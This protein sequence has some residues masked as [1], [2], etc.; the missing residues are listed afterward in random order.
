[1]EIAIFESVTTE[2]A[3]TELEAEGKKY[4]GLYV[5][6]EDAPQRKY[7][8]DKAS[9]IATLKKKVD[10]VRIDAAKTY[11][12][13]VEKQAAAIHERLDEANAPFQV[14]IDDYTLERKKIL[15]AEKA[16]KQA[17][18]DAAQFDLDHEMGLLINKTF[19]YDRAEVIRLNNEKLAEIQIQ[20]DKQALINQENHNAQVELNRVNAENARLANKEHCGKVNRAALADFTY[21]LRIDEELA[22]KIIGAIAKNEISNIQINY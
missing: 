9:L 16:R 20:A 19:E 1:M 13:E 21:K 7:V 10:R 12:L 2:S 15:D 6:M 4:D 8:K 5:D 11:K 14:L 18:L 3:L 17:I 22:R